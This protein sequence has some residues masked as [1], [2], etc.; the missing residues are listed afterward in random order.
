ML[1]LNV[2]G[3]N[4]QKSTTATI[5]PPTTKSSSWAGQSENVNDKNY[6]SEP[7]EK[8]I[9]LLCVACANLCTLLNCFDRSLS[10][11]GLSM[12]EFVILFSQNANIRLNMQKS[13]ENLKMKKNCCET[14]ET[15]LWQYF[16][17]FANN[18]Y[19]IRS[20]SFSIVMNL[21]NYRPAVLRL[22][23]H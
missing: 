16:C 12:C 22:S 5:R 15:E 7:K 2:V 4:S 3:R 17:K 14:I 11:R 18:I 9:V 13:Q 23:N 10:K 20:I 19:C 6:M 1:Q 8:T 21:R